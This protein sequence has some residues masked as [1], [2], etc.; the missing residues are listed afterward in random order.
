MVS[1]YINRKLWPLRKV[2]FFAVHDDESEASQLVWRMFIKTFAI[3]LAILA[4]LFPH[5][6]S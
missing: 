1:A 4:E 6:H 2:I 3:F 5:I